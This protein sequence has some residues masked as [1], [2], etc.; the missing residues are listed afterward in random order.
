MPWNVTKDSR[1]PASRPYGVSGGSTG[2]RLMGCHVSEDA[3]KSQQAALYAA[4]SK[5]DEP[6]CYTTPPTEVW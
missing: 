3:A 5:A 6:V 4:E 1:C 2:N